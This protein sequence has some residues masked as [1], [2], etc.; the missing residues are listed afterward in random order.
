MPVIII[1]AGW[2]GLA[3]AIELS[4][5]NI[6]VT[7]IEAA[8]SA[9]GRARRVETQDMVFDNGQHLMLGAYSELLRLLRVLGVSEGQALRRRPLC[10]EMRS[11]RDDMLRLAFPS[12][13]APWHA[14]AGF[15][16][17]KG[18]TWRERY[19]ALALCTQLFF[20]GF[21]LAQDVSVADWLRRTGQP[22]RLIKA[23]W[24]PLCLA[25]LN[26]PLHQASA[27]VFIRVLREAFAGKPSEADML[28]PRADLGAVFPEP[29]LRFIREHGG[30]VRFSERVAS[31]DIR[32][33]RVAG[34]TTQHERIAADHVIIATPPSEALRLLQPHPWLQIISRQLAGLRH[35]PICTVY[36]QYPPEVRLGCE[37]L[38]LLD[39]PG[40][41]IFDLGDAGHP[42]RMAVVISG[43]GLHMT[44]DNAALGGEVTRQVSGHFSAWPTPSHTF[45]IREKR[46]TFSCQV[47]IDTLRPAT[48]TPVAGCWLA[49]DYTATGLPATLEGA[50]RS[51]VSAARAV[52]ATRLS[53]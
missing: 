39:G 42:G 36:L 30:A 2:S 4:R 9:G 37:M 23:L 26:T 51:G 53:G 40:Q 38:G 7:L 35:E 27:R 31:L 13:P 24:E 18:L 12:L 21:K 32:D 34:V 28:F 22:E 52:I 48:R 20:S 11:P 41:F 1:G 47:D 46:A 17:A 29:A 3:A 50:L 43:P 33:G 19:R 10:L 8:R 44:E 15:V 6:Q 25:V 45:V 16:Q 49:G 5:A 14:L